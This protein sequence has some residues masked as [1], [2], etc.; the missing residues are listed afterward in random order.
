M[1]TDGAVVTDAGPCAAAG[2]DVLGDGGSA[3]DA[4][5]ASLFCMGVY[6]PHRQ[7]SEY[8]TVALTVCVIS[9]IRVTRT[10]PVSAAGS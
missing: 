2:R 3:V 1:F 4:A 8:C 7:I 6:H 5:I 9:V 10:A